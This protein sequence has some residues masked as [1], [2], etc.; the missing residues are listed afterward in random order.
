MSK[1]TFEYEVNYELG[2]IEKMDKALGLCIVRY[3]GEEMT[4]AVLYVALTEADGCYYFIGD[5]D[6]KETVTH[7]IQGFFSGME[8]KKPGDDKLWYTDVCG[9]EVLLTHEQYKA[10]SDFVYSN[11]GNQEFSKEH[12]NVGDCNFTCCYEPINAKECDNQNDIDLCNVKEAIASAYSIGDLFNSD[13]K[14]FGIEISWKELVR[15]ELVQ[16]CM[17][18]CSLND[19]GADKK[20]QLI[21]SC[22]NQDVGSEIFK[23]F[24]KQVSITKLENPNEAPASFKLISQLDKRINT[25]GGKILINAYKQT[26]KVL[27]SNEFTCRYNTGVAKEYNSYISMLEN[28]IETECGYSVTD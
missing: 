13:L 28:F 19:M 6:I 22:L 15:I 8:L 16:F 4:M 9:T 10:L 20:S 5:F 24:I 2:K 14:Q 27:L 1:T 17:Y 3:V 11:K 25:K 7:K 12:S 18:L 26:A 21:K 23:P